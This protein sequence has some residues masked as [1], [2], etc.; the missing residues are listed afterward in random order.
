S[1]SC[2][3][4]TKTLAANCDGAGSCPTA[5][6]V[7]C[8]PYV[9]STTDCFATCTGDTNCTSGNFC[10]LSGMPCFSTAT[11]QNHCIAKQSDGTF[12]SAANQCS[13][14]SCT[15]FYKDA[16]SDG[17]GNATS[18]GK[19]CGTAAPTGYVSDNTDCCDSD[20]NAHPGQLAYFQTARVGCG[21][22]DYNCIN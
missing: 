16:D 2:T 21:G 6:T 1:Q 9:C 17:Y 10:C 5:S 15:L 14:G 12:C 20:G 22:Y 11:N 18:S 7:S 4:S 19:F 13:S 8:S 3:G